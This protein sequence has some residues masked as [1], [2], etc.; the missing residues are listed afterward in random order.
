[1][2]ILP[3]VFDIPKSVYFA[4]TSSPK[5]IFLKIVIRHTCSVQKA[6]T[7]QTIC[8]YNVL[9]EVNN[10]YDSSVMEDTVEQLRPQWNNLHVLTIMNIHRF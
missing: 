4:Q 3:N 1:M 5:Q 8:A 7:S 2:S 10:V 9:N 6:N